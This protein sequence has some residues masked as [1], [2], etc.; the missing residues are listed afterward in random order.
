M[1]PPKKDPLFT[2]PS[3]LFTLFFMLLT[4]F[5]PLKV[6]ALENTVPKTPIASSLALASMK[7]LTTSPNA[8]HFISQHDTAYPAVYCAPTVVAMGLSPYYPDLANNAPSAYV[9][10]FAEYLSTSRRCGTTVQQLLEGLDDLNT[11]HAL[12]QKWDDVWYQGIHQVPTHYYHNRKHQ[13][14][15]ASLNADALNA[16]N[17]GD[18]VMAHLGWYV[19]DAEAKRFL[20][21]GGHYVLVTAAY[22]SP[23]AEGHVFL[24]ILDPLDTQAMFKDRLPRYSLD[25]RHVQAEQASFKV[26]DPQKQFRKRRVGKALFQPTPTPGKKENVMTFLEGFVVLSKLN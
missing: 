2:N 20:R 23:E 25:L 1:V 14:Q 12:A 17:A 6:H 9:E 11:Q 24:E 18:I 22:E 7:V 10:T 4:T 26:E 16:I 13:A 5:C 15:W 8:Y 21:K 3:C 19:E